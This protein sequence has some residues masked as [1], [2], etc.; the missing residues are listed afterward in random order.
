MITGLDLVEWQLRVASGNPLPLTQEQVLSRVRGCAIEARIY[1]E[2]PARDFLPSTG[3]LVH[4]RPIDPKATESGVRVDYGIRSG[5][6]VSTFYDPMIAKL[7]AFDETRD[8]AVAKLGRALREFQVAGVA[9]NIDFLVDTSRHP[10]FATKQSTTAFFSEH[11]SPI[12]SHLASKGA[13]RHNGQLTDHSVMALTAILEHSKL[14]GGS[15]GSSSPNAQP[16]SSSWADWRPFGSVKKPLKITGAYASAN[17]E[18]AHDD[19]V[20]LESVGHNK[21]SIHSSHQKNIHDVAP[22]NVTIRTAKNTRQT[23]IKG[24]TESLWELS[25]EINGKLRTGTAIVYTNATGATV[26]DGKILLFSLFPVAVD[27]ISLYFNIL[28]SGS[29]AKRATHPPTVS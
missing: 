24:Q 28:Q 5:D 6:T 11:L 3:R 10:G 8:K 23:V 25:L 4:L 7:I 13:L 27:V 22:V 21:V 14:V 29:R 19:I 1:A 18:E 15:S 12:L 26:A 20:H 9:N 16:W 17:K 2:N